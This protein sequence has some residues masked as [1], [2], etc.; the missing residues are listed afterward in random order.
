[1]KTGIALT[2]MA[3]LHVLSAQN[4]SEASERVRFVNNTA[5]VAR[6]RLILVS[7]N[8]GV[9]ISLD[10]DRGGESREQ[11]NF[12]YGHRAIVVYDRTTKK[13]IAHDTLD[14]T[15]NQPRIFISISGD[16]G[17]GYIISPGADP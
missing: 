14:W 5:D 15:T 10:A 6:A 9:K 13:V 8:P 16:S 1:M 4:L 2:L 11:G 3:I 17:N 7:I 12:S